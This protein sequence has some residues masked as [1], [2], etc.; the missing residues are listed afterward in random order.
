MKCPECGVNVGNRKHCDC[1]WGASTNTV[2][3]PETID[4]AL[5]AEM[6][7]G[8]PVCLPN[9]IPTAIKV[10]KE[11]N[12]PYLFYEEAPRRVSVGG[13]GEGRWVSPYNE[14]LIY[15]FRRFVCMSPRDQRI[16]LAGIREDRVWWRGDEISDYAKIIDETLKMRDMGVVAYRK[17]ALKAFKSVLPTN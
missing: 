10:W 5:F 7:G 2:S 9:Q 16:V 17:Q 12:E 15:T 3:Q 4:A 8:I 11:L 1:G 6:A 14:R 13:K